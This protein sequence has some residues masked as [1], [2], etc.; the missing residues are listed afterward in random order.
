M[1]SRCYNI[2]DT[3]VWEAKLATEQLSHWA[4]DARKMLLVRSF[5]TKKEGWSQMFRLRA[6]LLLYLPVKR[7]SNEFGVAALGL[8][9]GFWIASAS[10]LTFYFWYR[11]RSVSLIWINATVT[12]TIDTHL[13]IAEL[14]INTHRERERERSR[15]LAFELM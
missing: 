4:F 8:S 5:T 12:Q 14:F 1:Q 6:S 13:N 10:S 9:L 15:L 2:P 7:P 3:Q 11:R